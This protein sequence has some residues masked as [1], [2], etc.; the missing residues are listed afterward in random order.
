MKPTFCLRDLPLPTRV[1]IGAFMICIGIGYF[2]GLVQLHFQ[3]ASPGNLLPGPDEAVGVYYGQVGAAPA[4]Q[5]ERL[6]SKNDGPFNGTGSMKPAFFDKSERKWQ[7][8][9]DGMGAEEQQHLITCREGECQALLHWIRAGGPKADFEKDEHV[10]TEN[11]VLSDDYLIKKD[12]GKK[13]VAIQKLFTDRCVRCHQENGADKHAANYPLDDYPK[14]VKYLTVKTAAPMDVNKLAQ[15]THVHLIGFCMMF[16]L[17]G[18]FFSLTAYG[19]RLRTLIAPMPMIFQVIDISCWWL[20]RLNPLF[21][22][23]ILVTGG[24][25]GLS[26]AIHILGTLGHLSGLTRRFECSPR[27]QDT[28]EF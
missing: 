9:L 7:E 13:A 12:D 5:L 11:V 25:V 28:Q 24:I 2:A 10:L 21:A 23:V 4:C 16:A 1:V 18:T 6:L 27:P 19:V 26:L 22:Q 14:L 17:T 3:H 20:G 8:K 15:T